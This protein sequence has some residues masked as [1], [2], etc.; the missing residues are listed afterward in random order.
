VVYASEAPYQPLKDKPDDEALNAKTDDKEN[1]EEHV[2][3]GRKR[4]PTVIEKQTSHLLGKV[5]SAG[6][7]GGQ[8]TQ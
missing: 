4:D 6:I 7:V 8:Q 3:A 1:L 5:I 2:R